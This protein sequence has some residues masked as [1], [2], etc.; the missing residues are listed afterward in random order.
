MAQTQ[1]GVFVP[2]A[3]QQVASIVHQ[4]LA[5]QTTVQQLAQEWAQLNKANMRGWTELDWTAYAFTPDELRA[6]LNG[7]DDQ[8]TM[9][10]NTLQTVLP[11][12]QKIIG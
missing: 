3:A 6:A 4:V 7:L 12:L 5:L 10:L 9:A 2:R 1:A 11:K 8:Y